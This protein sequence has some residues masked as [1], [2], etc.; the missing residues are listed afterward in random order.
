MSQMDSAQSAAI[1]SATSSS[2]FRVE[3]GCLLRSRQPYAHGRVG[4]DAPRAHGIAE[5]RHEQS[6]P[7]TTTA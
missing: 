2:C 4:Q 1:S 3:L 5:S 6:L 7:D